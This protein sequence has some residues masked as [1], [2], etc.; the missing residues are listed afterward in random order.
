MSVCFACNSR[1]ASLATITESDSDEDIV[2][3]IRRETG[4][5]RASKA[6]AVQLEKAT[7]SVDMMLLMWPT[8]MGGIGDLEVEFAENI[9]NVVRHFKAQEKMVG[10]DG[11]AVVEIL[12]LAMFSMMMELTKQWFNTRLL[13]DDDFKSQVYANLEDIIETP[14][15]I[16]GRKHGSGDSGGRA[17]VK[18]KK[19]VHLSSDSEDDMGVSDDDDDDDEIDPVTKVNTIMQAKDGFGKARSRIVT[20]SGACSCC[21]VIAH[22]AVHGGRRRMLGSVPTLRQATGW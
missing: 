22:M 9:R 12:Q 21:G 3:K 6:L 17:V 5:R 4:V 14:V 8:A 18:K 11:G 19:M 10:G 2:L 15:K 7:V 1:F 13:M 20:V 16:A